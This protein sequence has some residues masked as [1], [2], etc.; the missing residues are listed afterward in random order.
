V[1]SLAAPRPGIETGH[2]RGDAGLVEKDQAL[3]VELPDPLAEDRPLRLDVGAIPFAGAQRL[4]A[5]QSEPPQGA[6]QGW[7][8]DLRPPVRSANC[9]LYSSRVRSFRSLTNAGRIASPAV[10]IPRA[11][12]PPGGLAQRRPSV[13]ACQGRLVVDARHQRQGRGN[14]CFSTPDAK[15]E[16]AAHF[17]QRF[18]FRFL[19]A[20]TPGLFMPMIEIARLFS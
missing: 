16:E 11:R 8:A 15:D 18:G 10:S 19:A 2:R 12:P 20:G 17:Y 1:C 9:S 3:G 5:P 4:F 6:A 14:S 7:P 13:R